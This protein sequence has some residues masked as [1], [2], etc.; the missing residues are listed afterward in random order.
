MH[1]LRLAAAALAVFALGCGQQMAANYP[2]K[3]I[4]MVVP[5][6]KGGSD[7]F[8][9]ALAAAAGPGLG[10]NITIE[11]IG[12]ADGTTG[13]LELVSRPADGY[14]LL[15]GIAGSLIIAPY[16]DHVLNVKW[17]AFEP[18]ARVQGEE[19]FLFV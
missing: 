13:N 19:E 5:F 15:E 1:H 17:D 6:A 3:D 10:H 12:G 2:D 18:V 7:A 11:N 14:Q 4:N 16:V 8:A 9:R